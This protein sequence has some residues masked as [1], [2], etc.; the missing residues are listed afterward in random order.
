MKRSEIAEMNPPFEV[1]KAIE[2]DRT[3]LIALLRSD[4]K[5]TRKTRDA[6]ADWLEGN[7]RPVTAPK[8]RPP[9]ERDDR[10]MLL[11]DLYRARDIRG[12]RVSSACHFGAARAYG[13]DLHT[14][15]GRAGWRYVVRW[16]FIREKGWHL[17]QAGR[18]HWTTENLMSKIAERHGI[19]VEKLDNYLKRASSRRRKVVQEY[20]EYE[21]MTPEEHM[22][23]TYDRER[24]KIANE[25]HRAKIGQKD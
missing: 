14:E 9:K 2:G 5:M 6:L 15:I 4:D 22:S 21:R 17:K 10:L 11:F 20:L 16:M 19:S 3:E 24:L 7:L 1:W 12:R 18:F 25:I 23:R 13:Y 8:G